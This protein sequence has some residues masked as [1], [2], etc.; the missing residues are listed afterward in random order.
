MQKMR[1]DEKEREKESSINRRWVEEEE[2]EGEEEDFHWDPSLP[3]SPP[4]RETW[5]EERREYSRTPLYYEKS[6]QSLA[7]LLAQVL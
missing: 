2:E 3:L 4:D 7:L 5:E 1:Y 6:R